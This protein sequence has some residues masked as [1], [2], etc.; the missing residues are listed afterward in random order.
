[1]TLSAVS[2]QALLG[3][4]IN[5]SSGWPEVLPKVR[6]TIEYLHANTVEILR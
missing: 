1:M 3:A 5:N 4:E 6:P 2:W